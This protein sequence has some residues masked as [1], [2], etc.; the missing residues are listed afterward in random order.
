MKFNNAT[1]VALNFLKSLTLPSFVLLGL[2]LILLCAFLY[3]DRLPTLLA[4]LNRYCLATI[5]VFLVFW[6]TNLDDQD[7]AM[8]LSGALI[9]AGFAV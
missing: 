6:L 2:A 1:A 3:P 4:F 8:V 5:F 9:G 7:K